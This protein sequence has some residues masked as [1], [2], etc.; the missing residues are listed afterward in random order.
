MGTGGVAIH[1]WRPSRAHPLGASFR[2]DYLIVGQSLSHDLPAGTTATRSRALSG[3]DA[4]A[5]LEWQ[6]APGVQILLG[7]GIEEMFATTYVD[8]NGQRVATFPP[9]SALAEAGLRLPF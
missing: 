1:P 7:A 4:F 6:C 2:L 3:A 9:T 5:D 8:L